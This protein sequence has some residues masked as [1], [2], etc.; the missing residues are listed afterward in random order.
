MD[1]D[2]KSMPK[3]RTLTAGMLDFLE[4]DRNANPFLGTCGD[5]PAAVPLPHRG[6]RLDVH[7]PYNPRVG[8]PG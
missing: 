8:R 7:R 1:K 5:Y 4:N 2:A 3:E 6:F